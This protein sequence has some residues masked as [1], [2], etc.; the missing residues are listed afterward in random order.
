M[1]H[2]HNPCMLSETYMSFRRVSSASLHATVLYSN[3]VDLASQPCCCARDTTVRAPD[4][5]LVGFQP[6]Q[7]VCCR[8]AD[9]DTN[10]TF[11]ATPLGEA[12]VSGYRAMGLANLWTPDLRGKIEAGISAVAAGQRTKVG[13]NERPRNGSSGHFS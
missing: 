11:S 7:C 5:A 1:A 4:N 13:D 3:V 10:M 12:L 2:L 6:L 9:K 8:Y